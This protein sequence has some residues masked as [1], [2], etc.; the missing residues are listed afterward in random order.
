M[1]SAPPLDLLNTNVNGALGHIAIRF[2]SWNRRLAGT[3]SNHKANLFT[4]EARTRSGATFGQHGLT[5]QQALDREERR[6][7]RDQLSKV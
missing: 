6:E 3:V 4:E 1:T 7:E 5:Q 2:A